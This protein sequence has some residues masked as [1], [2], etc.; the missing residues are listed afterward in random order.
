MGSDSPEQ[1]QGQDGFPLSFNES[2]P[3][4]LTYLYTKLSEIQLLRV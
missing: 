3:K 1:P 4:K 2:G